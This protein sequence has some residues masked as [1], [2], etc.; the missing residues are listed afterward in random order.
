MKVI[1]VA[2]GF[3]TEDNPIHGVFHKKAAE[4]L[5]KKVTLTVIHIRLWLPGRKFREYKDEGDYKRLIICIPFIPVFQKRLFNLN[6]KIITLF[7]DFFSRGIL[8][9]ADL[10]HA[11]DGHCGVFSTPLVKKYGLKMVCQF[12]GGDINQDL[13]GRTKSRPVLTFISTCDHF[14]FNSQ[15]IKNRFNELFQSEK[16]QDVIYRGVDVNSFRPRDS[17]AKAEVVQTLL[18]L[19]GL[20][21][22]KTFD[23]GRNTKGGLTIMKAWEILDAEGHTQHLN[24]LFAGPESDIEMSQNWKKRLR[25]PDSV[26]IVGSILPEE[27]PSYHQMS[28]IFL[29]AS[30]EEGLPNAGMEAA[31]SESIIICSGVGG[32]PEIVRAGIEAV[33]AKPGDERHWAAEIKAIVDDPKPYK[34]L[35]TSARRRME[36][37]FDQSKF[38]PEYVKVY[39]SI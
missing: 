26:K 23:H 5:S 3:P 9:N 18:F 8:L 21:N 7:I 22:Y 17:G 14:T 6:N 15:S 13:V 1:Y 35:A 25:N 36:E 39:D 29:L 27:V 12:I 20:P 24:L 2:G 31:A 38:A 34:K 11:G 30:L 32:I 19:G 4:R 10:L 37:H 16:P 33:F 28:D